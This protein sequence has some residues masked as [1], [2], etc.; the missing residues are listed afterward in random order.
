MGPQL[1]NQPDQFLGRNSSPGPSLSLRITPYQH[2]R[3]HP[4]A[5]P[6]STTRKISNLTLF[7]H[8]GLGAMLSW[9]ASHGCQSWW[10]VPPCLSLLVLVWLPSGSQWAWYGRPGA[11]WRGPGEQLR[12]YNKFKTKLV[13]LLSSVYP[14]GSL[15]SEEIM[16]LSLC[17]PWSSAR[18][19]TTVTRPTWSSG[20]CPDCCRLP[21][22]PEGRSY[23]PTLLSWS[24]RKIQIVRELERKW[25]GSCHIIERKHCPNMSS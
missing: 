17:Q 6:T 14:C 18:W 5:Q 7:R 20:R 21:P 22:L 25:L 15:S 13:V 12:P 1:P 3:V 19:S 2:N 23:L 24:F 11:G 9:K 10:W 16:A 4:G 8:E